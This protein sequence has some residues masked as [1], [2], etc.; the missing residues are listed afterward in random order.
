MAGTLHYNVSGV[1]SESDNIDNCD[2]LW[3]QIGYDF[4]NAYIAPFVTANEMYWVLAIFGVLCMIML[5]QLLVLCK[6]IARYKHFERLFM[7]VQQNDKFLCTG[8]VGCDSIYESFFL[9]EPEPKIIGCNDLS[10]QIGQ[11]N[12][13]D[14][15]NFECSPGSLTAIMG[16]SGSGKTTL[17]KMV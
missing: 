3:N 12:I 17:L 14:S 8:E 10:L 15:V 9:S 4:S 16:P 6:G 13:L 2:L 1:F 5:V 11:K 7:N